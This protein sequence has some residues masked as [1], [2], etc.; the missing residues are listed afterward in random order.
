MAT[1]YSFLLRCLCITAILGSV[2]GGTGAFAASIEWQAMQGRERMT[3]TKAMTEGMTGNITRIDT[4]GIAIPFTEVPSGLVMQDQPEKASLIQGSAQFGQTLVILTQTPKFGFVVSRQTPTQIVIDFFPDELGARWKPEGG[5]PSLTVPAEAAKVAQPIPPSS[6]PSDSSS[7]TPPASSPVA[8]PTTP[9]VA[10]SGAP[11]ATQEAVGTVGI[12]GGQGPPATVPVANANPNTPALPVREGVSP[13]TPTSITPVLTADG[14]KPAASMEQPPAMPIVQVPPSAPSASALPDTILLDT[15][16]D[17]ASRSAALPAPGLDISQAG[18]PQPYQPSTPQRAQQVATTD[19]KNT[20]VPAQT[21]GTQNTSPQVGAPLTNT[22]PAPAQQG[23]IP[24]SNSLQP[25]VEQGTAQAPVA[26]PAVIDVPQQ[27]I[28]TA[29]TP[30]AVISLP[31]QGSMAEGGAPVSETGADGITLFQG[32]GVKLPQGIYRGMYNPHGSEGISQ[33]EGTEG[34][35]SA[36]TGQEATQAVPPLGE[37][38]PVQGGQSTATT[39]PPMVSPTG[40]AT[41]ESSSVPPVEGDSQGRV[42]LEAQSTTNASPEGTSTTEPTQGDTPVEAEQVSPADALATSQTVTPDEEVV[43]VNEQ[44]EEVIPPADPVQRLEEIRQLITEKKYAEANEMVA[45]LLAQTNLTKDQREDALHIQAEMLFFLYRDNLA[46]HG[47]QI[48]EATDLAISANPRSAKNAVALLR[49]GYINLQLENIPEA[50]ARFNLLRR[51]YPN[52]ENV[53]LSY[54]YWGDYFYNHDELERAIDQFQVVTQKYPG[55]RYAREASLGLARSFYRL[56]Y[57]EQAFNI[58]EYIE[59][60]WPR[61]YLNYP[62]FL[63]MMGDVA[64]RLQNYD[65]A[66][67]YYW[68]YVNLTPEGE[69]VDVILTRIGDIYALQQEMAAAREVYGEVIERFP[70]TDGGLVAL[71]RLAEESIND[72]PTIATM[73][74]AFDSRPIMRPVDVYEK[75]INEYPQSK[76]ASLAQLKLAMWYLWNHDYATT[77]DLADAFLRAKPDDAL[78]PKMKE[79]ALKTFAILSAESVANGNYGRMR[80]IWEQYPM[81]QE[82]EEILTPESRVALGISYW[83]DGRPNDALTAVEPFFLGNKIPEY[84]ETAL[85]LVLGIYLEYEQWAAVEE[86]A[87]RVALWEISEENQTQLDYALALAREQLEKPDEA[88]VLWEKLYDSKKLPDEKMVYA[89]YFLARDAEKRQ[90]NDEAYLLGVEALKRLRAEAEK[91]PEQADI[92]KIISQIS[93]LMSLTEEGGRLGESLEYAAEYLDH[94]PES[95]PDRAAV[96]FRMARIHKKQGNEGLW[97]ERLT[98]IVN[99]YPDS[100]YGQTASAALK[101]TDLERAASAY[102]PQR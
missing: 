92:G 46:Q 52:D 60:R 90:R 30:P 13:S 95:D 71:M 89:V 51:M 32:I 36:R 63:N 48:I 15:R 11:S 86:V 29:Q 70:E 6:P 101:S 66:T 56:G 27:G 38:V 39:E 88:A 12:S 91:N 102:A 26:P 80:N 25:H 34:A 85:T 68:L 7:T 16:Q 28:V 19:A 76:Y 61:F 23:K 50:E 9:S 58:V 5:A 79:V 21:S 20:T 87:R 18:E 54:Y 73:F 74:N 1:V 57:Y 59:Q 100:V 40:T 94:L 98:E 93:S 99:Q 81:L 82:Q 65:F 97:H 10:S 67:R 22:Q 69:E 37:Q 75:I 24:Q 49:L 4:K 42:R 35:P 78:A 31:P 41:T 45:A 55:S 14:T 47:P 84:S 64:F 2:F 17:T 53:P 62:P 96:L 33:V 72:D 43:Y 44:G 3:I 8:P 83:K 77:L